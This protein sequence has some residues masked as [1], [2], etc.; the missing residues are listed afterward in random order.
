MIRFLEAVVI[1]LLLGTLITV[2]I[3]ATLISFG[4]LGGNP[5]QE[6]RRAQLQ[7]EQRMRRELGR[8]A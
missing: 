5:Y 4:S 7:R 8:D 3:A 1:W 6:R 2:L